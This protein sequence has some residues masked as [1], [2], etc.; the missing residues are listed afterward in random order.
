MNGYGVNGLGPLKVHH[1]TQAIDDGYAGG[2]V[3]DITQ[4]S[5]FQKIRVDDN[6]GIGPRELPY[7]NTIANTEVERGYPDPSV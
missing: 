4:Q 5:D 7:R 3:V 6:W 1:P 2:I